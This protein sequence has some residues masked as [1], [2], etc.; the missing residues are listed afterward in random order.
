M[1]LANSAKL[2][3]NTNA[4]DSTAA[5]EECRRCYWAIT[6]LRRLLGWPIE[7]PDDTPETPF[8]PFPDSPSSPQEVVTSPE[9]NRTATDPSG[10]DGIVSTVIVLSRVWSLAQGYVRSRGMSEGRLP[11]WFQESRYGTCMRTL[12]DLGKELSPLHRYRQ[13][14]LNSVTSE[15]LETFRS[16]WAPWFLGRFLYHTIICLINHPLLIILQFQGSQDVSEIFLQQTAYLTSHHTTWILHFIEFLEPRK[17]YVTDPI[18]GYC[19]AVIAT[20]ELQQSFS[21]KDHH[22]KRRSNYERCL[23]FIRRLGE[24]WAYMH[25]LVSWS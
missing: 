16:Y 2:Y 18:L 25:R 9:A 12:L 22:D 14:R 21:D 15:E 11:P 23:A 8:P 7:P 1:T 17:F 13:V 19:T 24:D 5:C 4:S 3:D 20:I 10:G 6:L